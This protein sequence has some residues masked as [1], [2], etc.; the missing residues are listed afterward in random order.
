[1][2]RTETLEQVQRA[3][4]ARLYPS[5]TNANWLVLRRRREIFR[6]WLNAWSGKNPTVLDI[7]GRIQPYRPLIPGV[8]GRY[9]AVDLRPTILVNVVANAEQLPFANEEF[10]LVLCTQ[11]LEYSTDPSQAISEIHR[12]LRP[13]G[14][15]LLSVPSLSIRDADE[16]RWRFWPAGIQQLLSNFSKVDIAPEGGSVAGFFRTVNVGLYELARYSALRTGLGYTVVPV[17]NLIGLS[18][19]E[20]VGVRHDSFVVNYSALARK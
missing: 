11:M 9:V 4:Q 2:P 8:Q 15:L 17:L 5:L 7:G 6:A 1:M 18:L 16:D 3:G 20:L 13:G 12:V 19:D 10:D 14:W